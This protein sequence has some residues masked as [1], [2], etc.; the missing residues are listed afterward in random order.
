M[1]ARAGVAAHHEGVSD[2]R[3]AAEYDAVLLHGFGGPEGPED[4]MPYLENVTRGRG[5]PRERLE[6]V[7][8]H[9]LHLGG[10]S[11]INDQNRA[12]LAAMREDFAAH[13]LGHLRL[14]WGN[15]NWHPFLAD[16]VR[17]MVADGVRRVI[18]FPTAGFSS[19]S[20]CRQY[21]ED[22]DRVR[23]EV[24][25]E[26]GADAVPVVDKLRHFY[27]HP[28]Y[29]APYAEGIVAALNELP[30]P[31]RSAARIVFTA[32]S[33]PTRMNETSGIGQDPA[34]GLYAAEMRETARLVAE[35]V[36]GPWEWDLVWQSR[37]GP[38]SQP[39][40]EPDI[41][42]HLDDLHAQGVTEVVLSP[43]GFVSDHVEVV[44]DLDTE[45]AERAA[46]LGMGFSRAASAGT[47]PAFVAMIRQLVQERLDPTVPRR[48]LGER[49]VAPDVCAADCCPRLRRPGSE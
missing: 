29:V 6:E 22:I 47:H 48:S 33:I 30:E 27:N 21:W 7:S 32:H 3:R 15:R 4:V 41:L 37:S 46:E 38:P 36:A 34:G 10:R 14:Y 11:P 35:Q 24:A 8:E 12:L 18:A 13:G 17:E 39:W 20:S 31:R 9:Y 1:P 49:G 43:I 5:I 42:D 16:V 26:V 45:A 25:A 28:G 40:L 44:W 23:T 19:Y 2:E